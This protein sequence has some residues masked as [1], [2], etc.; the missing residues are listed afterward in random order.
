MEN[1]FHDLSKKSSIFRSRLIDEFHLLDDVANTATVQAP[2]HT[3]RDMMDLKIRNKVLLDNPHQLIKFQAFKKTQM[4]EQTVDRRLTRTRNVNSLPFGAWA[5]LYP[6]QSQYWN[7]FQFIQILDYFAVIVFAIDIA[8][9]LLDN[10]EEFWED[11]WKVA[12][13]AVTLFCI[14][15]DVTDAAGVTARLLIRNGADP[16]I[17]RIFRTLKLVFRY[18]NFQIMLITILEAFYSMSSIMLLVLIV[19]FTY[20]VVGVYLFQPYTVSTDSDLSFQYYFMDIGQS[21]MTLF[22]L[23]TLDQWDALNLDLIKKTESVWTTLF[24]ISWVCLGAFI[25]RNIFIGVLVN[26]FHKISQSLKEQTKASERAK[27]YERMRRKLSRELTVQEKIESSLTHLKNTSAAAVP[28]ALSL[29]GGAQDTQ[30]TGFLQDGVERE[31]STTVQRTEADVLNAVQRLLVTNQEIKKGWDEIVQETL[32]ALKDAEVETMWPRDS[33]FE[34]LQVMENLHENMKEYEE[35]QETMDRSLDELITESRRRGA[36][37]QGDSGGVDGTGYRGK[38]GRRE[39]RPVPYFDEAPRQGQRGRRGRDER[40]DL[41][42]TLRERESEGG[43]GWGRSEEEKKRSGVKVVLSNLHFNAMASDVDSLITAHAPVSA[44][45]L[46]TPPEIDYDNAGRSLGTA[47]LLF[48]SKDVAE[49]V[50][51]AL[52]GLSLLGCLISCEVVDY[53]P[54]P[55]QRQRQRDRGNDEGQWARVEE[56]VAD[57]NDIIN[58]NGEYAYKSILDRMGANRPSGL[59]S[60]G[61]NR[62]LDRLGS[63]VLD[64]LGPTVVYTAPDR[65]GTGRGG[66]QRGQRHD[67]AGDGGARRRPVRGEDLDKEMDSY[68]NGDGNPVSLD[69]EMDTEEDDRGRIPNEEV[70]RREPRGEFVDFDAPSNDPYTTHGGG[71]RGGRGLLDYGDL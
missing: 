23:L 62:V 64:R 50:K 1:T 14:V 29:A 61:Q 27:N 34:Y 18:S 68:M 10:F 16:Q 12:D 4:D 57:G 6:S 46:Q 25:F 28:M 38:T 52:H 36:R 60:G 55:A 69:D 59:T 2:K 21:M 40:V 58:E 11:G 24:I 70:S 5:E 33:L 7:L 48:D 20:S 54:I 39:R 66:R 56:A 19:A 43:G 65:G 45:P 42:E 71:A 32:V 49:T 31:P 44:L 22:Q 30:H 8:L 17:F 15:P 41:R 63:R 47:T 9:K 3:S 51:A 26:H 35:L 67:Y 13:L 53:G 37:S